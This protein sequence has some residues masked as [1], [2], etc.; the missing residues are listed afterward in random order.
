MI[1]LVLEIF[2]RMFKMEGVER[3]ER[4]IWRAF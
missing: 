1:L 2:S 4:K 3:K